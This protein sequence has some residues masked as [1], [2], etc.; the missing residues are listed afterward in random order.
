MSNTKIMLQLSS[1]VFP[2]L[3]LA[4]SPFSDKQISIVPLPVACRG[5]VMPRATAWL[6]AP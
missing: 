1:G 3:F 2:N 6:Y 4:S 5:L